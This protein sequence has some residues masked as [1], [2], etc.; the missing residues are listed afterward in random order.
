MGWLNLAWIPAVIGKALLGELDV[1]LGGWNLAR[2]LGDAV[3]KCLKISDLLYLRECTEARRL[4][5]RCM[6]HGSTSMSAYH[7]SHP[8]AGKSDPMAFVVRETTVTDSD[9]DIVALVRGTTVVRL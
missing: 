3:P 5:Y 6:F 9:N 2:P 1:A 4:W 8:P 7:T